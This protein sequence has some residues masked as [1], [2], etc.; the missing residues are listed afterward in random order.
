VA[1]CIYCGEPA[2]F[3]RK[4]HAACKSAADNARQAIRATI[5]EALGDGMTMERAR[6]VVDEIS[7]RAHV[8]EADK[9]V[10]I[11]NEVTLAVDRFLEDG[12][13][14]QSEENRISDL[15]E[16]FALTQADFARTG[17]VEKVVKA[18]T[19]RDVMNGELPDRLA[20]KGAIPFNLQKGEKIIWAFPN[21]EYLEDKSRR[22]YVGGSQ[23]VS[24]R[25]AKGVYYRVGAFKGHSVERT[26][27]VSVGTG[28]LALSNKHILFSGGEKSLRIPYSKIVTFQPFSDGIAIVRDAASA[29]PQI[30]VTGD[31]WFTYNLASN[32]S[33]MAA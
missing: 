28:L 24:V 10:A 3:F 27:R 30:F 17:A 5:K 11:V 18:A 16:K 12:V 21:A 32:L 9:R 6:R 29:K 1:N 7:Q 15:Q 19:L 33:Q 26:E 2:G 23:G 13:L 31:G 4:Q 20:L 8:P 25:I 14:D 22:Q